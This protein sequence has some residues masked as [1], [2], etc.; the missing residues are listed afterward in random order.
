MHARLPLRASEGFYSGKT[1]ARSYLRFANEIFSDSVPRITPQFNFGC[2]ET[3][4]G[5]GNWVTTFAA[6]LVTPHF[7]TRINPRPRIYSSRS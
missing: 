1:H 5:L 6:Q 3:S 2:K 4:D 7:T